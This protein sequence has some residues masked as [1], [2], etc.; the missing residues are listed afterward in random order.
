MV[1]EKKRNGRNGGTSFGNRQTSGKTRYRLSKSRIKKKKRTKVKRSFA[2]ELSASQCDTEGTMT[3]SIPAPNPHKP[4]YSLETSLKK[5]ISKW[6]VG[7]ARQR[8]DG[9]TRC[10]RERE[11]RDCVCA[12]TLEMSSFRP[13]VWAGIDD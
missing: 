4:W 8:R 9:E 3:C 2:D 13:I 10:V 7:T 12:K 6:S 11:E 5:G 1:R